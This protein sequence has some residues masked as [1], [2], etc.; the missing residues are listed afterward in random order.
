VTSRSAPACRALGGHFNPTHSGRAGCAR[1][2]E[3]NDYATDAIIV[4][5]RIARPGAASVPFDAV[6]AGHVRRRQRHR[7]DALRRLRP[8]PRRQVAHV[9]P[10]QPLVPLPLDRAR[11]HA[12]GRQRL[13]RRPYPA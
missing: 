7:Q 11:R 10:Q 6:G 4:D 13:E 9:R 8:P 1:Y 3:P 5:D 12:A 2:P